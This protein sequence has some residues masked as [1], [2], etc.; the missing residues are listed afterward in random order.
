LPKPVLLAGIAPKPRLP[1]L[2][3]F[4]GVSLGELWL[5]ESYRVV[6]QMLYVQ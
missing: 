6:Q 3:S 5:V 2:E 1:P 4:R